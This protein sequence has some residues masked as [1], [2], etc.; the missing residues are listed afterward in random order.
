MKIN[1]IDLTEYQLDVLQEAYGIGDEIQKILVK[2]E[3]QLEL[4]EE[5]K[6]DPFIVETYDSKSKKSLISSLEDKNEEVFEAMLNDGD[7]FEDYILSSSYIFYDTQEIVEIR[8]QLGIDSLN[9]YF[10]DTKHNIYSYR[11][12][13]K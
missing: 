6:E 8:T 1:I 7:I 10:F 2:P 11:L 12:D 3:K 4:E 9:E 5:I 13:E